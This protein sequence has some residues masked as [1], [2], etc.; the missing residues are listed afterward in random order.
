MQNLENNDL[1]RLAGVDEDID[2]QLSLSRRGF[3]RGISGA[4]ALGAA[5]V[6][7][8]TAELV[9]P[10]AAE[11]IDVS[12]NPGTRRS[13][14]AQIRRDAA[15][16][17]RR[18]DIPEH[19]TNGDEERYSDLRAQYSKTMPHNDLGEPDKAAYDLFVAAA[20]SG[21][22]AD[23]RAVPQGGVGRQVSPQGGTMFDL[24]GADSHRH[25]LR[26]APSFRSAE[27][28]GE[29]VEVYW[30]AL[31][32]D[33]PFTEYGSNASIAAAVA[34]LNSMTDFNGP[35]VGSN[36][37]TGTLFRGNTPGDLTGP[38]I[39]QFLWANIPY[40]PHTVVQTYRTPPAGQDHMTT[41]AEWLNVQRGGAPTGVQTFGTARYLANGRDLSEWLHRDFTYQGFLNAALI[42]LGYGG[43]ALDPNN[44]YRSTGFANQA[45]FVSFGGPDILD[46]VAK[47]GNAGLRAAWFQKWRVHRRLR[48]EVFGGRIHN[49]ITG[50]KSYD[51]HPDVLNSD[52]AA[53]VFSAHGNYLLPMA[54][55][56][57]SPAHPAYPAGHA[58]ISGACTTILKAFFNE[59][60]VIPSAVEANA[61]GS[62]LNPYTGGSLTVGGELNKL[63]ANISLGR[64]TAGV[65]WRSDGIDGLLLGEQVAINLLRDHVTTYTES[66]FAGFTFTSF[67][68]Q[69]ITIAP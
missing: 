39:S 32:R 58:T 10:D 49:H 27:E 41:Y 3:L 15:N 20:A 30:Q 42:I 22:S 54:F 31:T 13:A 66:G 33:V 37:T 68:G 2:G 52:A 26:P 11:A 4:A 6:A 23:W 60:F 40:G 53:A 62:A 65:H 43:G 51:I 36:V 69:T 21:D 63:A 16:Y 44:P 18:Q 64:D 29:M 5:G 28:A 61:D 59:A 48:P 14:A 47:A 7:V 38:Y 25:Y 12:G 34:D 9:A 1:P 56:E 67:G 35:K 24:E 17:H 45:A 8:T 55:P 19:A 46:L 57:G 50:A